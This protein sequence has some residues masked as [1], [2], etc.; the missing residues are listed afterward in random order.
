MQELCLRWQNIFP[1]VCGVSK[2]RNEQYPVYADPFGPHD[3]SN[4]VFE[5]ERSACACFGVVTFGVHMHL[6]KQVPEDTATGQSQFLIWVPTRA[7]TK[8]T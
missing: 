4:C 3:D 7:L 5:M 6:F 8:Q 1:D 2:W